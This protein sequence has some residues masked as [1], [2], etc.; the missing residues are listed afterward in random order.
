MS[1]LATLSALT[2][3]AACATEPDKSTDEP[4]TTAPTDD[5]RSP[6][7]DDTGGGDDTGEPID[8]GPWPATDCDALDPATCALPWPSSLYLAP[9]DT[10][11]GVALTF[12]TTSLPA[13]NGGDHMASAMFTGLDGYGLG[14]PILFD[15]GPLDFAGLPGEW[16]G[17]E[18][19]VSPDSPT[20]LLRVTDDGL[21]PVPHWVEPDRTAATGTHTYLRPAVFLAPSTRYIVALRDLRSASGE[22]IAPSP[23]F[24]ALQAGTDFDDPGIAQRRDHFATLFTELDEAGIEPGGLTLAWDFTTG[25]SER[26]QGRLDGALAAALDTAPD[27]ATFTI[28]ADETTEW[29]REPDDSDRPQ[30]DVVWYHVHGTI[31][32]PAVVSPPE[33]GAMFTLNLTA[34]S[35]DDDGEVFADGT[36]AVPFI[37]DVPHRARTSDEPLGVIVYGHGMFGDRW[38]VMADHLEIL[39]ETFGYVV[40]GVPLTGMSSPDGDNIPGAILDLDGLPVLTD[41]L[42]QGVVDHH[43]LV[44]AARSGALADMLASVDP[45]ITIDPDEVYWFGSSQG[46]IFGTT[47]MATSPDLERG[48][49]GVPGY[50]Y[51]TLL[52]RSVNF[53]PFFD[54]FGLVYD[55]GTDIA[56]TLAAI[57]LLWDRTDPVSYH[58]RLHEEGKHIL[59]L[60]SKGDKQVAVVTNELAARTTPDA[61]PFMGPYDAERTPWDV[62][63]VDYPRTGS[64]IV[65]YDF[66]NAWPTDRGNLPPEDPLPDPHSRIAEVEGSGL[67]LDTFLRTGQIIDVCGGD[68]CQ[69]D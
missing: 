15:V 8:D 55:S 33:Q 57:Q 19:S 42:H 21:E 34:P 43:M 51:S 35:G 3:L 56:V 22:P 38:E 17:L 27:G 49:L 12:G 63:Q 39:A 54:I 31:E 25:S 68:G 4:G 1:R 11:T 7:T 40:I 32:T 52:S 29:V 9:A 69:P 13:N 36:F 60:V 37:A 16:T 6:G 61:L 24:A 47:I 66:G 58:Q 23:A 48:A 65:L 50:N 30:H 64:G 45:R 14:T 28:D 44:R 18:D 59:S 2:L 26:L 67:Q 20:L 53:E 10:P 46:G 62:P 41:G 5:D